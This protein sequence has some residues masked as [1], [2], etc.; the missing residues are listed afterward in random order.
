LGQVA[1]SLNSLTPSLKGITMIDRYLYDAFIS[2][3]SED[4]VWVRDILLPRLIASGL[5]VALS[6]PMGTP[7]VSDKHDIEQLI[8][9]S[10]HTIAVISPAYIS[11]HVTRQESMFAVALDMQTDPQRLIPLYIVPRENLQNLPW[12]TL[13]QGIDMTT[14]ETIAKGF[15]SLIRTLKNVTV[16]KDTQGNPANSTTKESSSKPSLFTRSLTDIFRTLQPPTN[17]PT[18]TVQK[19]ETP[20]RTSASVSESRT[21]AFDYDVFVAYSQM[22]TEWIK[23]IL[24]PRLAE[25]RLRVCTE[26]YDFAS[27]LPILPEVKQA[28]LASSK[29]LLV[30]TGDYLKQD[31][32]EIGETL[33]QVLGNQ[34]QR[35]VPFLEVGRS[36]PT[37]LEHLASI[38]FETLTRRNDTWKRLLQG[39]ETNL[40]NSARQEYHYDVFVA[41]SQVDVHWAEQELLPYLVS[42]GLRI[43][44]SFQD[45][46][47]SSS[48]VTYYERAIQTSYKTLLVLTSA[49][50]KENW[51]DFEEALGIAPIYREYRLIP[52]IETNCQAPARVSHLTA[53]HFVKDMEFTWTQL[54]NRLLSH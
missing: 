53:L 26:F 21:K 40:L 43:R 52:L 35:L 31:W 32:D 6:H 16:S 30:L 37:S 33:F 44:L 12:I 2:Y 19:T 25:A 5:R 49:Y 45:S 7:G 38:P 4:Q 50:L 23:Q 1:K 34:T 39:L 27:S 54:L 22:D 15:S 51:R 24:L 36:L 9:R 46:I 42:K 17:I 20:A 13:I 8:I 10:R 11:D 18:T 48:L 29:T 14:A 28:I 3:T 41:C 47:P